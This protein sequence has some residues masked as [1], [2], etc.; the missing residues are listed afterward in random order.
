MPKQRHTKYYVITEF[1]AG[2]IPDD[3]DSHRIAY[4]QDDLRETLRE[5]REYFHN[6]DIKFNVIT[7]VKDILNLKGGQIAIY[8]QGEN[9]WTVEVEAVVAIELDKYSVQSADSFADAY[10]YVSDTQDLIALFESEIRNNIR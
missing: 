5:S 1:T 8:A 4:S 7:P 3:V 9:L 2:C 10:N 6:S